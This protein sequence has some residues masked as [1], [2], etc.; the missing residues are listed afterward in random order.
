M[1]PRVSFLSPFLSQRVG[2]SGPRALR[3]SGGGREPPAGRAGGEGGVGG[4]EKELAWSPLGIPELAVSVS[5]LQIAA[6]SPAQ[7]EQPPPLQPSARHRRRH[8][9]ETM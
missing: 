1:R 7:G 4:E 2:R 5:A 8:L 9:N 3:R 6:G